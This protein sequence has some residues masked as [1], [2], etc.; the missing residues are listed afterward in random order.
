[1]QQQHRKPISEAV[2]KNSWHHHI[3]INPTRQTVV[4]PFEGKPIY[5]VQQSK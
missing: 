4:D 3:N 1:M 2:N 5:Q